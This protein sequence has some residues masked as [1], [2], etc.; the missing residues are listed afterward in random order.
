M[1]A[2][3]EIMKAENSGIFH[4]HKLLSWTNDEESE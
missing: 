2:N 1:L 4:I 3:D